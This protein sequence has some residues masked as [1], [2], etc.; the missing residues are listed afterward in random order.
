MADFVANASLT[1]RR[2][3][4][5][6]PYSLKRVVG[7]P[8][9]TRRVYENL[10]LTSGGSYSE[11]IESSSGDA[12]LSVD[13]SST[14]IRHLFTLFDVLTWPITSEQTLQNKS[15]FAQG[16]H[17]D[18]LYV[19]T[20]TLLVGDRSLTSSAIQLDPESSQGSA[21]FIALH[22]ISADGILILP[23]YSGQ[24]VLDLTRSLSAD[25]V[26]VPPVY[27]GSS[28]LFATE[29][30]ITSS[31][32]Y[33]DLYTGQ[34]EVTRSP[35]MSGD[36]VIVAPLWSGSGSLL[37]H[38]ILTAIGE[39]QVSGSA[40]ISLSRDIVATGEFI[41]PIYS[42]S[43]QV[44]HYLEMVGSSQGILPVYEGQGGLSLEF[45]VGSSA[46]HVFPVYTGSSSLGR[47]LLL[48]SGG[49]GLIPV[50]QSGGEVLLIPRDFESSGITYESSSI[51][52]AIYLTDFIICP[53]ISN[54]INF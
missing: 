49:S 2:T 12:S 25:S 33:L 48:T 9:T 5:R 20:S 53:V 22:A 36:G 52:R 13:R 40:V 17:V 38:S 37:K 10:S 45:S 24:A 50:Y 3:R 21:S 41:L 16:Q 27:G 30:T 7:W 32:I 43:G 15:F 23:V 29:R 51:V 14:E 39:Y 44:S 11:A 35:R 18:P 4:I 19:G 42:G 6:H 47:T 1:A 34:S 28:S 31:V 8:L 46:I 26:H 54:D